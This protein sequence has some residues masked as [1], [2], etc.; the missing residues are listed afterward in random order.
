MEKTE[1][2][3]RGEI[4]FERIRELSF[5]NRSEALKKNEPL[6]E[7]LILGAQESIDLT[8][9]CMSEKHMSVFDNPSTGMLFGLRFINDERKILKY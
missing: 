5:S 6:P 3:K 9:Y 1:R 8:D 4:V 7:Y 2:T